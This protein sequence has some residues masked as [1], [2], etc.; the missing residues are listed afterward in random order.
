[1]RVKQNMDSQLPRQGKGQPTW[2]RRTKLPAIG[3]YKTEPG[4]AASWEVI[5]LC[6]VSTLPAH[7]GRSPS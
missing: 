6:Q 5:P 1:M 7:S 4:W 3:Q 2:V